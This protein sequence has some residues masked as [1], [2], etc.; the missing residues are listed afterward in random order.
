MFKISYRS[1][2]RHSSHGNGRSSLEYC[3]VDEKRSAVAEHLKCVLQRDFHENISALAS[4][5]R[6]KE[7]PCEYFLRLDI[8]RASPAYDVEHASVRL[9]WQPW[10]AST[11]MARRTL[12]DAVHQT[13]R[14]TRAFWYSYWL[15]GRYW[16]SANCY[17]VFF[18]PHY[19]FHPLS[20][21][22]SDET[23][24]KWPHHTLAKLY[25]FLFDT[26]NEVEVLRS[27]NS[28]N[29][30]G[31]TSAKAWRWKTSQNAMRTWHIALQQT[32]CWWQS[33]WT[34]GESDNGSHWKALDVWIASLYACFFFQ[35]WFSVGG[36][37]RNRWCRTWC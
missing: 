9:F 37:W 1:R 12:T 32:N 24:R 3:R 17:E 8:C 20:A 26:F 4:G 15:D 31:L 2:S 33:R 7:A 11:K 19:I 25:I 5:F 30:R 18:Q 22:R 14:T 36:L 35:I 29:V 34:S 6:L 21:G 28:R 10:C 16:R 23:V 27:E 13:L